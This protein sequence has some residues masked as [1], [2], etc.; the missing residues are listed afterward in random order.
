MTFPW[1]RLRR[2]IA[3]PDTSV[4]LYAVCQRLLAPTAESAGTRDADTAVRLIPQLDAEERAGWFSWLTVTL[5]PPPVPLANAA[6]AYLAEPTPITACDLAEAAEPPRQALLRRINTAA[7]GTLLLVTLRAEVLKLLPTRPDLAPLEA[8]LKHLL[9]SWF[10]RGFLSLVQID[11][12][13]PA[14]LLEKLIAYEAVHAIRNWDDLRR[15]LQPDRRCYAFFHPALPGEPLIFV[16]VALMN[17]LPS[18]IGQILDAPMSKAEDADTAIFYSISN[19]YAGLRGISFGNLLIKQIVSQL[20][21]ELPA[22]T[23]FATLSPVPTLKRW[24]DRHCPKVDI[25]EACFKYLTTNR[26]TESGACIDPVAHFH[27]SNGA[28]LER[29]MLDADS[30]SIGLAQSYGAMVNYV[31]D[32]TSMETNAVRYVTDGIVACAPTLATAYNRR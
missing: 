22:L 25:A 8:D 29:I 32:P 5:A 20:D 13:S 9:T 10:N 6:R 4:Q 3:R 18:A 2:P 15:R 11:W 26:L 21:A 24:Y 7:G 30:S 16:E 23:R 27:L 17:G 12:T 28:Q 31:Y 19:C 14:A 1:L